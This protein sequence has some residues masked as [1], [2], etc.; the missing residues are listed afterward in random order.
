M[1]QNPVVM[2]QAARWHLLPCLAPQGYGAFKPVPRAQGEQVAIQQAAGIERH[3]GQTPQ[4]ALRWGH[5]GGKRPGRLLHR[6]RQADMCVVHA[7]NVRIK[8]TNCKRFLRTDMHDTFDHNAGMNQNRITDRLKTLRERAGYTIREFARDLGYG[9]KFSSYRMYETSYKKDV[10]PLPM[11]K[12]MVPLLNGKGDPPITANEV[13]NLAGVSM[14]EA[15]LVA[16]MTPQPTPAPAPPQP[17]TLPPAGSGRIAI[18]EYDVITSAGPGC[19]PVL[20]APQDGLRPVEHWTLPRGYVAAFSETPD[21]LA[22]VRVAGDSM[23]PDYQSGDRVL[24]DTAHRIP[25]PPGVYVLWDGFGLVLKRLELIPGMEEPRRVRIMSINSAY[26]TYELTLD[27]ISIN[28]RV[29]GKWTW[30]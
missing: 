24:V 5:W 15:G 21:T 7:H 16:K 3:K 11:V 27:E 12:S 14:G 25:S 18:P 20:C 10:L 26:S 17:D 19:V 28:G 1:R 22:I 30:K 9:E 13:W 29:V 8:N 6:I 4:I 2:R 23:E